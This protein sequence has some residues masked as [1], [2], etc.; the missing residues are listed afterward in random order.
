M[1]VSVNSKPEAVPVLIADN[2]NESLELETLYAAPIFIL[3]LPNNDMVPVIEL[4]PYKV[5]IAPSYTPP[6]N[7]PLPLILKGSVTVNVFKSIN[8][9][10][11]IFIVVPAS[12]VPNAAA[13]L[14]LILP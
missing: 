12:T 1:V 2:L 3:E 6:V 7:I 14:I 10:V 4:M 9:V 11:P 5:L 13:F 8:T